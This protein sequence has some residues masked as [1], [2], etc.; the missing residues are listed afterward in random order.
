[1]IVTDPDRSTGVPVTSRLPVALLPFW[2]RVMT[3]WPLPSVACLYAHVPCHFPEMSGR[4]CAD[5]VPARIAPPSMMRLASQSRVNLI[6]V[7]LRRQEFAA[8]AIM[9]GPRHR[10]PRRAVGERGRRRQ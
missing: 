8:L 1:M 5:G 4:V 10:A 6:D 9:R 3:T 7:L 2:V